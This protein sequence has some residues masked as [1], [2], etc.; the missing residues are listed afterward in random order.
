MDECHQADQRGEFVEDWLL[1]QNA[2][3]LN[4]G[5]AT[6]INRGTCGLSTPDIT[7]V[8][9]AWSTGTE[10]TVVEDLGSDHLPI[11]TTI[12]C[13]EPAASAPHR[14]ARWN[15][16]NVDSNTFS[17]AVEEAIELFSLAPMSLR[18]RVHR[19][20]S[21]LIAAAKLN[22]GKSK[23]GRYAKPWSTP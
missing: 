21:A 10:W 23:A 5:T 1:S 4:D 13:K 12:G 22:V 9:N 11:T 16:N 18:N 7:A 2:S 15:M 19:F 8:S 6:C 3:I 14:R 20:Y 17:T